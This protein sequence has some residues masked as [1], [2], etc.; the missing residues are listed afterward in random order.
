MAPRDMSLLVDDRPEDGVFRVHR[1][2][3]ASADLFEQERTFVFERTWNFLTAESQVAKP[4]DFATAWIARTPVIVTRDGAGRINAFLNVC[5]HKGARIVGAEHG[6]ARLL[7]CPYHGWS[8]DC[9]GKN[10]AIKDRNAAHYPPSF[11]RESHDLLPLPRV[12]SY[13]GL[14]FGSLSAD[15][16]PLAEFL[17]EMRVFLDLAMDQGPHGMEFVPG[18]V[19]YTYRGN[20]KLQLDNGVDPYHLTSTHL[21]FIGIQGRRRAGEGNLDARQFDWAKR[22]R[23]EAGVFCF[24]HGHSVFWT[25]Q[26]EA[27]KRPIYPAIDEVRARVG[28]VRAEWMLR[29][30]N[31]QVFPNLQIADAMTLMLRTFRP[32]AVDRTEMRSYCLAPIGEK[33]E[34]RAWRLRQFEDFFNPTGLAT[35]D[36]TI[37]YEDCQ[38][39]MN[40]EGVSFLQGYARGMTALAQGANDAARRLGIAPESSAIGTFETGP[41]TQ[42]QPAYR[43]WRRLMAAGFAGQKPYA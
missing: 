33:P 8:Y 11:D 12:E 17:G 30:R 5:R 16:P 1:D 19:A 32:L 18:R 22:A 43:E 29:A 31:I 20:W 6:N 9:A 23:R 37:V 15:V 28:A 21:S 4:N 13:K 27:E 35:P 3:F 10:H 39:G 14:I 41:E 25:D 42:F 7:V 26:P 38:R 24:P 2:V 34:L 40:A 36:D